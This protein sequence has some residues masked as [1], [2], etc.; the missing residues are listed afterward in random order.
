[1]LTS[2]L[3][4]AWLQQGLVV[5]LHAAQSTLSCSQPSAH[6]TTHE[7][8]QKGHS[9]TSV[10]VTHRAHVLVD[11]GG[12][13]LVAAVSNARLCDVDGDAVLA[14]LQAAAAAVTAP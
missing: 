13:V 3:Q 5:V 8:C 12:P 14:R 7:C 1:M 9:W 2:A 10:S 11:H 6:A 4:V